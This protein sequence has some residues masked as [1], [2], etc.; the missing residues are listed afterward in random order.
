MPPNSMTSDLRNGALGNL[1]VIS[2][3]FQCRTTFT[4]PPDRDRVGLGEFGLRMLHTFKPESSSE[5]VSRMQCV[6]SRSG[7][8]EI[9]NAIIRR[10]A[11]PVVDHLA[12]LWG[13]RKS[14]HHQLMD[15]LF[16][17]MISGPKMDAEMS[18]PQ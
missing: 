3:G 9:F 13:S 15:R 12:D 11:I 8:F 16:N 18:R 7:V 14:P 1:V 2:E 5:N 17:L 10:I 4:F 6:A